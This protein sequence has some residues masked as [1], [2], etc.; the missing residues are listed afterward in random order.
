[1]DKAATVITF[2]IFAPSDE[3]VAALIIAFGILLEPDFMLFG[4]LEDFMLFG[5]L[6]DLELRILACCW[7][8]PLALTFF[9]AALLLTMIF[10]ASTSLEL[11]A[12]EVCTKAHT[13]S[14]IERMVDDEID[15]MFSREWFEDMVLSFYNKRMVWNVLDP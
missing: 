6:E 11:L 4:D 12:N 7:L 1:M 9:T 10:C 14:K 3:A 15:F 5:D 13:S 2:S 8:F